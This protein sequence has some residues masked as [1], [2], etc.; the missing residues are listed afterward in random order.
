MVSPRLQKSEACVCVYVC[1]YQDLQ[2]SSWSC[3]SPGRR[4]SPVMRLCDAWG[5]SRRPGD[6]QGLR[7]S[8]DD[9]PGSVSE[10]FWMTC[11]MTTSWSHAMSCARRRSRRPN[12]RRNPSFLALR[13]YVVCVWTNCV[14]TFVG[15]KDE[16]VIDSGNDCLGLR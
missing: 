11:V 2:R 8:V 12:R 16:R 1:T 3:Y 9:V 5:Y 7:R 14:G 10:T 4:R 13:L 15:L 6:P